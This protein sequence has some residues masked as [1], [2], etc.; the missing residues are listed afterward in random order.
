VLSAA[1]LPMSLAGG[2][3]EVDCR[4]RSGMAVPSTNQPRANVRR[5]PI[6]IAPM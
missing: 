3:A 2:D 4:E 5:R 1:G 6:K